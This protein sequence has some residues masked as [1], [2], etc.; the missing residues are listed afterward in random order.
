M[1]KKVVL[2]LVLFERGDDVNRLGYI[3]EQN[4]EFS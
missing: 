4:Y 1:E 3:I 2:F